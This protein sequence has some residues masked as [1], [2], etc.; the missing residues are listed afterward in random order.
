MT[1]PDLFDTACRV[2]MPGVGT[3]TLAPSL[4]P[5]IPPAPLPV[6]AETRDCQADAI[7]HWLRDGHSITPI[8]ALN[9]FGCFRL[10]ARIWELKRRG[11]NIESKM[12]KTTA[13]KRVA[14]YRLGDG[15]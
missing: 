5:P 2:E 1:Q 8:Q 13:G 10:G 9:V 12:I 4:P 14:E 11:Y 6:P 7:L 3:L 15:A